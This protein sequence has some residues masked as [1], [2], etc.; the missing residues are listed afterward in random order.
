MQL[1]D[2]RKIQIILITFF[3]VALLAANCLGSMILEVSLFGW[4]LRV[5]AGVYPFAVTFIITDWVN[6]F[7][8]RKAAEWMTW[9]GFGFSLLLLGLFALISC[10]PVMPDSPLPL[11]TVLQSG[12]LF[13]HMLL[14]SMT[15]YL[16]GQLLDIGVFQKIRQMTKKRYFWLRATASTVLS[17]AIDT[18]IVIGIAFW[19]V[20]SL[21]EF[22]QLVLGNYI[23]K[24]C[25][26]FGVSPL[27]SLG[28]HWL[29]TESKAL[30]AED[31]MGI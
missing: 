26:V 29:K 6:E 22:W 9:L 12:Q 14:A 3:V 13:S 8:G 17:Q 24:L 18:V 11:A 23:W 25:F 21:T 30:F 16:V 4:I 15:A 1:S 28:H 31:A 2:W 10:L 5:S 19:G 27:L 20:Y 7:Y